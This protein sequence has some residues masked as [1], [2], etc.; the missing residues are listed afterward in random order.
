MMTYATG[1]HSS[2]DLPDRRTQNRLLRKMTD[3]KGATWKNATCFN[4]INS[5][6][7]RPNVLFN[8]IQFVSLTQ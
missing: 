2:D 8:S 3:E 5:R 1:K 7:N 6:L 4:V